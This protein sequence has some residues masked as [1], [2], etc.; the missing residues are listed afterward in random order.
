MPPSFAD[1]G[2]PSDLVAALGRRSITEPFPIQVVS[3]PD[4]LA[5]RDL[6]GKAPT[7]SGKTLA[8]GVAA[9]A[10]LDKAPA[11][12]KQPEVLVLTPTRELCSQ[13]ASEL[14]TLANV[15]GKRVA[16]F[17]GGVGYD[18]QIKALHR[19]VDIAVAC[20]GRLADLIE[21]RHLRLDAVKIVVVDE[22][23]RMSDMGFLPEVRKSSGPDARHPPDVAL[24]GHP[25]RGGRRPRPPLPAQPGTPRAGGQRR[26]GANAEHYFWRVES[27]DRAEMAAQIAAIS[28]P[29]HRLL[30]DP[31]LGRP[32]GPPTHRPGVRAVAIHGDRSQAQR[33][34]A[35]SSF[36]AGHAGA[37][38]ATDVAARGIHVD[39]VAA[40]VHFDPT[41][42]AEGLR[43]PFGPDGASRRHRYRGVARDARQDQSGQAVA[44]GPR[45][46]LGRRRT[47]TSRVPPDRS[48]TDVSRPTPRPA[49][50]GRPPWPARPRPGRPP[51]DPRRRRRPPVQGRSASRSGGLIGVTRGRPYRPRLGTMIAGSSLTIEI[52]NRI[53]L[54][55]ASF[56]VG[57]GEKVGL[58]GR[59]GDGKSTLISA[60]LGVPAA[61]IRV[62]WQ[63]PHPGHGRILPQVPTPEGLGLDSTGFSHVL[64]AAGSRARRRPHPCPPGHGEDP[65]RRQHRRFSDS[66]SSSGRTAATRSRA[67]RP[68]SDGL[69]LRQDLLLEDITEPVRGQRRR[70]DLV[71]VL[72]QQAEMMVLDEPTN[73][74][75][76][77]PRNG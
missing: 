10:R 48:G 14:A 37:L 29:D 73:H 15:R 74:L 53:L 33:E 44:A 28:G 54:R 39:G 55:D 5:G 38:V 17:Y 35:L 4:A 61:G 47:P 64:S 34:R 2:V 45:V 1:L 27:T 77:A 57:D 43:P 11:K 70:L 8:F 49:R 68:L 22:A 12:P 46:S 65:T 21:G 31:A 26:A 7:G 72:F 71:R 52:G 16:T 40:V 63:R 62:E 67:D 32:H 56:T 50:H 41:A 76:L 66:R 23:D 60:V 6:C 58:V 18:R 51:G 75:D 3:I 24:L 25:R 42:D 69:G 59:N 9:V 36:A 30:P 13:V 20:P 19:G